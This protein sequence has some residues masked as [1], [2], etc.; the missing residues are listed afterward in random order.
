MFENSPGDGFDDN[1]IDMELEPFALNISENCED[2]PQAVSAS[3]FIIL[4]SK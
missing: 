3:L 2:V 4:H 1:M